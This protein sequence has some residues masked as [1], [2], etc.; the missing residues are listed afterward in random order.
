VDQ[1]IKQVTGA[2]EANKKEKVCKSAVNAKNSIIKG[3][4]KND[5]KCPEKTYS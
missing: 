1:F 3:K 2:G 5:I 4:E